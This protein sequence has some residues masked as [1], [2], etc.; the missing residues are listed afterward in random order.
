MDAITLNQLMQEG[1]AFMI[2]LTTAG[3]AAEVTYTLDSETYDENPDFFE[4]MMLWISALKV[5][6]GVGETVEGVWF[7]EQLIWFGAIAD[8]S[9]DLSGVPYE[10]ASPIGF[11]SANI[12]SKFGVRFL[13]VRNE[14][15]IKQLA[16]SGGNTSSITVWGVATPR[17]A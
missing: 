5:E 8:E 14:F 15:S 13:P 7:D 4:N 17:T 2:T 9:L 3:N 1:K 16:P 11:A 10:S 6:C 12:Q